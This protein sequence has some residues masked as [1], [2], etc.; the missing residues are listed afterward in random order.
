[1]V[2][3]FENMYIYFLFN[4]VNNNLCSLILGFFVVNFEGM[5]VVIVLLDLLKVVEIIILYIFFIKYFFL[6]S[7]LFNKE[8]WVLLI[9]N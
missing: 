3:V 5:E 4:L 1:M 9:N 8:Y 7:R 6:N 2:Y